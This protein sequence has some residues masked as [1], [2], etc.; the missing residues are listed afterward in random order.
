MLLIIVSEIMFKGELDI[1][2]LVIINIGLFGL[3]FSFLGICF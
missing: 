3:W 1:T 2:K